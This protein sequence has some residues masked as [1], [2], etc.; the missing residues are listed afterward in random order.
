MRR[1]EQDARGGFARGGRGTGASGRGA[2]KRSAS[3]PWRGALVLGL[4]GALGSRAYAQTTMLTSPSQFGPSATLIDFEDAVDP[5]TAQ[6]AAQG[7]TF[8]LT[9]NRGAI[10]AQDTTARM[11]GPSGPRALRNT[12]APLIG[13]KYAD[14]RIDFDRP[15]TRVAFEFRSLSNSDDVQLTLQGVCSGEP[16]AAAQFFMTSGT[17]WRFVGLESAVP[18]DHVLV[19]AVGPT[20]HAF[21][22][23]NLRFES[24]TADLD[25]DGFG[26]VS[27]NCPCHANASQAD[28]DGD[29]VGDACDN[30]PGLANAAQGDVDG[31]GRGDVCDTNDTF[32]EDFEGGVLTDW[33]VVGEARV[34]GSQVGFEPYHGSGQG[35]VASDHLNSSLTLDLTPPNY[36]RTLVSAAEIAG[37]VGVSVGALTTLAGGTVSEGS[38]MKR[39]LE[40]T[41]GDRVTF[42]WCFVSS[43]TPFSASFDD[44]AFVVIGAG[45]LSLLA[46]TNAQGA[47]AAS[48]PF[49]GWR[50]PYRLF[51]YVAAESGSLAL[52]FGVLDVGNASGTSGL[53]VDVVTV[54]SASL[55]APPVCTRDLSQA[56]ASFQQSAPGEFIVTEGETLVVPFTAED[57][58]GDALAVSALGLPEGATLSPLAGPAPLTAVFS[59]TPS[60][61]DDLGV[62]RTVEVAFTDPSGQSSSCSV[63]ISDVNRRPVCDAGAPQS[64]VSSDGGGARVTLHGSASDP[65]DPPGS[66]SFEW[67][68]A[69]AALDSPQ[70]ATTEGWFPIGVTTAWLVVRDGRGGAA[71]NSVEITVTADEDAPLVSCSTSTELLW[72]PNHTL[73]DVEL[74]IVALDAVQGPLPLSALTVTVSSN[75]PDDLHGRSDGST[76][77]DTHGRDGFT[78]PVDVSSKLLRTS[79]PGESVVL[80]RLRAERD[81][82]GDGR[83]YTIT[84]SGLDAAGNSAVATCAVLVPHHQGCKQK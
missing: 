60:A 19:E 8:L 23:D 4:L 66:L 2:D 7:A 81:G 76:L 52:A 64:V 42:R 3:A 54:S 49:Y 35:L 26:D 29:G 27:D 16:V 50:T 22:F 15:V 78:K 59:W 28:G 12:I 13:G 72:P 80:L 34:V 57:L 61:A 40:V 47:I 68:A 33:L 37:F 53:L 6:Y 25:A 39:S 44:L 67:S 82:R 10:T 1:D 20:S 77:H 56:V 73:R 30:C 46:D 62:A 43:E 65:D 58:D 74:R 17:L 24:A 79:S 9:N 36:G 83:I 14:L 71:T 38:A 51:D 75:E 63:T 18:F 21:H 5:V 70:A 48:G 31:D 84:V 45:E 69:G 55:G 41:A 32:V 11:F